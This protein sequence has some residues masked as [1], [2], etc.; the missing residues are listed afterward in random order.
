MSGLI[1]GFFLYFLVIWIM[2]R[3]RLKPIFATLIF[4]FCYFTISSIF[5]WIAMDA[6]RSPLYDPDWQWLFSTVPMV[7]IALQF[8][9]AFFA[10]SKIYYC[11]NSS[12]RC[13]LWIV[14]GCLGV[15]FLAPF[16]A[17]KITFH[18]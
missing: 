11:D 9:I 12:V 4:I 5:S 3:Y 2:A 14:L 1:A 15:F 17:I 6:R 8:F 7:T 13:T 10:F 18:V 16:L